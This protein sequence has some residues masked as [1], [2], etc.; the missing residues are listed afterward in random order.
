MDDFI[1]LCQGSKHRLT[2]VRRILLHTV[3]DFLKS[4]LQ[5]PKAKEPLSLK[6][7][8]NGDA[9]WDTVKT[10]LGWLINSIAQTLSL[11]DHRCQR[12]ID[13]LHEFLSRKRCTL[14][15]WQKL[16]GELRF[17]SPGVP[18]SRGL[19]AILQLPLQRQNTHRVR[20]TKHLHSHLLCYLRLVQGLADRPTQLNERMPD[21]P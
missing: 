10:V 6:K 16:L 14:R 12:T 13:L 2:T 8:S 21:T 3:D 20:I 15:Q 1:A 19:F 18:G 4:P 7:L 9:S 5:H 11:P 17:V